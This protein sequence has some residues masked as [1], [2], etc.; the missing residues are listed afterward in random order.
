[1][2]VQLGE[3]QFLA[4]ALLDATVDLTELA[5][6]SEERDFDELVHVPAGPFTM[7]ENRGQ[8]ASPRHE[9]TL[10]AFK[11]AKYPVTNTQYLRF[12]GATGQEGVWEVEWHPQKK[13]NCP[14]TGVSWHDARAYCAW[15]T[16][17]WQAAGKLTAD[18][19]VRLPTEAEWEKAARG[20]G[21]CSW[22]W[23]DEWAEGH[24]NSEELGL[25]D[26][27][28]AGMFPAGA[29][30]YGCMDMAGQV[31]EWTSSLWGEDF[32]T[33]EFKYPY[34][35]EDGRENPSA[36]NDVFRVLRGGSF[37]NSW[38]LARCALRN[39]ELPDFRNLSFG[40]RIV[41]S[42]CAHEA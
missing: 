24:C 35:P 29:S 28:P 15:L 39:R 2:S 20:S 5:A 17:V 14:V 23:G 8:D 21:G 26:T 7:G 6:R 3:S 31:W 22:P 1:M 30:P 25:G 42:G 40:F 9:L 12:V 4:Q 36:G 18:E 38:T 13:A 19:I 27:C 16:R 41:V 11:M 33:P 34:D 10:P 37:S 32:W